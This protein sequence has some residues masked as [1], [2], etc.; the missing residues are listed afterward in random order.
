MRLQLLRRR[1][2]VRLSNFEGG[3]VR[4]LRI[5]RA[6]VIPASTLRARGFVRS[7]NF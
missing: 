6:R 1:G 2:F 7:S 4:A 3:V 5:L